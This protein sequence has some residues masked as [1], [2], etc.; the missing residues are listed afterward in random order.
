MAALTVHQHL[1]P[2]SLQFILAQPPPSSPSDET[3]WGTALPGSSEDPTWLTLQRLRIW[4]HLVL[5][6]H[7]PGVRKWQA[8]LNRHQPHVEE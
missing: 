7:L 2:C 3:E 8:V 1:G 4:S 6:S 5:V